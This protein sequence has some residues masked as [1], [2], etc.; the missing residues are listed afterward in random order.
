MNPGEKKT[1]TLEVTNHHGVDLQKGR[2]NT[3]VQVVVVATQ[4]AQKRN[5]TN[6]NKFE[7]T[8]RD[9]L[10]AVNIGRDYGSELA[11]E[12]PVVHPACK[13]SGGFLVSVSESEKIG[14]SKTCLQRRPFAWRAHILR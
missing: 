1:G 12:L 14:I 8:G 6:D 7:T 5:I 3:H 2:N 13:M 4:R 9:V 11:P 10:W